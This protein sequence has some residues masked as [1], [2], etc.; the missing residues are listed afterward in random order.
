MTSVSSVVLC[1]VAGGHLPGGGV[2]GVC[3]E[4]AARV[5]ADRHL[6]REE[7]GDAGRGAHAEGRRGGRLRVPQDL[8]QPGEVLPHQTLLPLPQLGILIVVK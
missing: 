8:L 4:A 7:L 1:C 2:A 5:S 6:P 3:G